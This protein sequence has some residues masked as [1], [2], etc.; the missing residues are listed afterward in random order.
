[1]KYYSID[2]DYENYPSGSAIDPNGEELTENEEVKKIF[3][4]HFNTRLPVGFPTAIPKFRIIK[5]RKSRKFEAEDYIDNLYSI[6]MLI[7]D[8]MKKIFESC[9]LPNHLFLPITIKFKEN[10]YNN[11]WFFCLVEANIDAI[12]YNKSY[13]F[14]DDG[15]ADTIQLKNYHQYAQQLI[16]FDNKECLFEEMYKNDYPLRSFS[17]NL[18]N[19]K[20]YDIIN[21]GVLIWPSVLFSE[22]VVSLIQQEKLTN[23]IFKEYI[24]VNQN[25]N[26]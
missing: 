25:K 13:F 1:M 16:K 12:N 26:K 15:Q 24:L 14:K 3:W 18:V 22:K 21:F 9:F 11:Y 6:G 17:I 10:N 2:F 20:M 4:G 5:Y 7:S 8:K 19:D 23:C